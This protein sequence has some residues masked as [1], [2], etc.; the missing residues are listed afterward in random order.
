MKKLMMVTAGLLLSGLL[1]GPALAADNPDTGQ[2]AAEAKS[3]VS[4]AQ[5]ELM[6]KRQET[7]QRNEDMQYLRAQTIEAERKADEEAKK[8]KQAQ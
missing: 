6:K 2:E 7:R 3:G 1:L 8:K 5:L 4:K